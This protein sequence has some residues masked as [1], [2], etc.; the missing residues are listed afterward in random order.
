MLWLP[1]GQQS[2]F[3]V[4]WKVNGSVKFVFC[5]VGLFR[6][7]TAAVIRVNH[8]M[9]SSSENIWIVLSFRRNSISSHLASGKKTKKKL[10]IIIT[11]ITVVINATE[12]LP[13]TICTICILLVG[14]NIPTWTG[15]PRRKSTPN[16]QFINSAGRFRRKRPGFDGERLIS[17]LG[18]CFYQLS[19]RGITF[20]ETFREKV[21]RSEP[22][23]PFLASTYWR[24]DRKSLA[25]IL[26][27]FLPAGGCLPGREVKVALSAK[28]GPL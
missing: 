24:K 20:H 14:T 28:V 25:W 17:P 6:Q 2:H 4:G 7:V 26:E 10:K 3:P 5:C 12:S 13:V 16:F 19:E 8:F 27:A 1:G 15:F 18:C 23:V 11:H 22:F 9:N 21:L